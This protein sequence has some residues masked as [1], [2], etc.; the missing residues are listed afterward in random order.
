MA[1]VFFY[2]ISIERQDTEAHIYLK[3]CSFIN[4]ENTLNR[5]KFYK[6]TKQN[7]TLEI[8]YE[9]KNRTYLFFTWIL[10]IQTRSLMTNTEKTFVTSQKTISV[11]KSFLSQC[12]IHK[13]VACSNIH[14][15]FVYSIHTF[16]CLF[17]FYLFFSY[18]VHLFPLLPSSHPHL[19]FELDPLL[20]CSHSKKI[21]PPVGSN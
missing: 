15:E 20:L 7:K 19:P 6:K 1:S 12:R 14:L 18:T 21:S 8:I 4:Y 3:L 16:L 5:I 17:A 2:D 9:A 13:N 11:V 10:S